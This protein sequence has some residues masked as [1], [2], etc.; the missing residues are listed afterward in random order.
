VAASAEG[1]EVVQVVGVDPF[2][3]FPVMVDDQV[4]RAGTVPAPV[5]IPVEGDLPYALPLRGAVEGVAGA[6]LGSGLLL[7][8]QNLL[9]AAAL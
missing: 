9:T 8:S 7:A 6:L 1:L 3:H 5:A 2:A 4:L